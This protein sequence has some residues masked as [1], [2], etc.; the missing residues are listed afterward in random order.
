MYAIRERLNHV[1]PCQVREIIPGGSK[2]KICLLAESFPGLR[3]ASI[4]VWTRD[5]WDHRD[6]RDEADEAV[7]EP[8]VEARMGSQDR[9]PSSVA[10]L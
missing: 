2:S 4:V 9:T 5:D 10:S 3:G 6:E 8:T 7:A 1:S